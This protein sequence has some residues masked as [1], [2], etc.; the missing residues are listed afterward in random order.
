MFFGDRCD[1]TDFAVVGAPIT[2]NSPTEFG[3]IK[4]VADA[5]SFSIKNGR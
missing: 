2:L 3:R 5:A 1:A 4:A